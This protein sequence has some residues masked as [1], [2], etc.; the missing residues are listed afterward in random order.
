MQ[1][2]GGD[3]YR[4]VGLQEVIFV[5]GISSRWIT[6]NVETIRLPD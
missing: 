6:E 5:L 1:A 4:E 2:G 3:H